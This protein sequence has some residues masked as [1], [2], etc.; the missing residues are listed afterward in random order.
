MLKKFDK[1]KKIKSIVDLKKDKVSANLITQFLESKLHQ[2]LII[3]TQNKVEILLNFGINKDFYN[4]Q[5]AIYKPKY[6][7]YV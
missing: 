4:T 1:T 7:G 3:C 6:S 5:L 2:F